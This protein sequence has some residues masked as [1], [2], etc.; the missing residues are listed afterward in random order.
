MV[1][2][3]GREG[4]GELLHGHDHYYYDSE[5]NR[6]RTSVRGGIAYVRV[7]IPSVTLSSMYAGARPRG[8]RDY[9]TR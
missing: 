5:D 7:E 6:S 8:D 9:G 2:G 4:K 3:R 1:E